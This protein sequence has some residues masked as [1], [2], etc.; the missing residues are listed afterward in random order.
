MVLLERSQDGGTTWDWYHDESYYPN[1]W[2]IE[3]IVL[4]FQVGGR[5]TITDIKIVESF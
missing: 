1:L 4:R 3:K 5:Y 2:V